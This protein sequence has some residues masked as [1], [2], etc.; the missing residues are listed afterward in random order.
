MQHGFITRA[1][2][3]L[4]FRTWETKDKWQCKPIEIDGFCGCFRRQTLGCLQQAASGNRLWESYP[5]SK[6]SGFSNKALLRH[7]VTQCSK[8]MCFKVISGFE[9]LHLELNVFLFENSSSKS[10]DHIGSMGLVY[11]PTFKL[12]LMVNLGTYTIHELY[13]YWVPNFD[14]CRA[15]WSHSP[16]TSLPFPGLWGPWMF[17]TLNIDNWQPDG[18]ILTTPTWTT[19]KKGSL[20]F[21]WILVVQFRDPYNG[22]I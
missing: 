14:R 6:A 10:M 12:I 16:A 7:P 15:S 13:G 8:W 18:D 20:T 17:R 22:W 1:C 9:E 21:H 3:I 4:H 5:S 11:L 2:C 19:G